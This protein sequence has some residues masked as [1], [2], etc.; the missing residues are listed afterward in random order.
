LDA[1][2][3]FDLLRG[4]SDLALEREY[5]AQARRRRAQLLKYMLALAIATML[6]Y[7][8]LSPVL[9]PPEILFK[10]NLNATL[11]LALFGGYFLLLRSDVFARTPSI[12]FAM[13]TLLA[14][15]MGQTAIILAGSGKADGWPLAA[16]LGSNTKL[17][18]SFSVLAF[19]ASVRW[20]LLWM[21]LE[22]CMYAYL[23]RSS[24][25]N[26][27]IVGVTALVPAMAVA[28]L[29]N[30]SLDWLDRTGFVA[31][32]NLAD[33]RAHT[34]KLLFNVLPQFAA[35][36]LKAGQIVADAFSEATVV[37]V[38]L[39]GSS[40]FAR[41]LAPGHFLTVLNRVFGAADKAAAH[42]GVEKVKTIGDAYLAIAGT[43]AP[44]TANEAIRFG[45]QVIREMR[46]LSE[47]LGLEIEV[48]IG[49]HTGPVVGGVIGDVRMAYDYWGDTMNVAS[50]IQSAAAIGGITV[51]RQTYY[52][53]RACHH[54]GSPRVEILKGIGE[55]ELF[56][57]VV[58]DEPPSSTSI[59]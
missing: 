19:V 47:E 4:F 15:C 6:A 22:F 31:S 16:V 50:R 3:R 40:E 20:Y 7:L 36:R 38:D 49:M 37:F 27:A 53:T 56:D 43:G 46:V 2:S 45:V 34:E 58:E 42:C 18:I 35:E 55:T 25:F 21:V 8:I 30:L 24:D 44:G 54:Y 17:I 33:E 41:L 26:A 32:R 39:V 52:A 57:L 1:P 23:L 59:A 13:F 5:V 14:I 10:F 29:T 12:D 51:S 9:I 28:L 48:R 11:M